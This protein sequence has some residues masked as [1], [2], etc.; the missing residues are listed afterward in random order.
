MPTVR[1]HGAIVTYSTGFRLHLGK[2][3]IFGSFHD[4]CGP[5]FYYDRAETKEYAAIDEKDPIWPLFNAWLEKYQ[6]RKKKRE[7][8][9][10]KAT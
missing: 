10:Q 2:R 3:Y 4:Y 6:H 7:A 5:S 1:L 8:K 9:N